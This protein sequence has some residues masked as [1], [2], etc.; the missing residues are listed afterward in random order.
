M[1]SAI[2]LYY[3]V[4]PISGDP[5]FENATLSTEHQERLS[6]VRK[7]VD[8]L[9]TVSIPKNELRIDKEYTSNPKWNIISNLVKEDFYKY[10][11]NVLKYQNYATIDVPAFIN[12][13]KGH[14]GLYHFL[15][16]IVLEIP[17]YIWNKYE[18]KTSMFPKNK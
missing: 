7:S 17:E 4:L 11:A 3:I 10:K 2:S 15:G 5:Y 12:H 18:L 8:S 14:P 13:K 16:N 1:I 9:H 6:I